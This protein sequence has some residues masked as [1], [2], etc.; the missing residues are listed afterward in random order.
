LEEDVPQRVALAVFG[1][2][3]RR[4]FPEEQTVKFLLRRYSKYAEHHEYSSI[5]SRI[6]CIH[7]QGCHE[8]VIKIPQEILYF[9]V[10]FKN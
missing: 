3:Q 8:E 6:S 5:V 4:E 7:G 10:D 1:I 9:Y 2:P